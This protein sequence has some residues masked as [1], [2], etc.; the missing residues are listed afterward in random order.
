MPPDEASKTRNYIVICMCITI[1]KCHHLY[2]LIQC[3]LNSLLA[4]RLHL[5]YWNFLL[6]GSVQL[7]SVYRRHYVVV[8][9]FNT[10]GNAT[11]YFLGFTLYR[12]WY[13]SSV[14]IVLTFEVPDFVLF[15]LFMH[16]LLILFICETSYIDSEN[17]LMQYSSNLLSCRISVISNI[18]VVLLA[19]TV[20]EK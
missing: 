6:L 15:R 13:G 12:Y 5:F 19:R 10:V 2:L 11:G 4:F 14:Y 3:I 20:T 16:M 18:H 7:I 1:V 9:M 8:K 17:L